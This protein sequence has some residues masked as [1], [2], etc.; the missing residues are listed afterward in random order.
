VRHW[1]T[2]EEESPVS[3]KRAVFFYIVFGCCWR[4]KRVNGI[5]DLDSEKE[6]YG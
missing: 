4:G 6:P 3:D 2:V 5:Y 1:D